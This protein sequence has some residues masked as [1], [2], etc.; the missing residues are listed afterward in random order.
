[1]ITGMKLLI[2]FLRTSFPH[3]PLI[4]AVLIMLATMSQSRRML[5]TGTVPT[6]VAGVVGGPLKMTVSWTLVND[7]SAIGYRV[8]RNEPPFSSAFVDVGVAVNNATFSNLQRGVTYF[9]VVQTKYDSTT[10]SSSSATVSIVVQGFSISG[11]VNFVRS[12]ADSSQSD[13]RSRRTELDSVVLDCS[14]CAWFNYFHRRYCL[15]V[16][17]AGRFYAGFQ[18]CE[19]EVRHRHGSLGHDHRHFLPHAGG[20]LLRSR[21]RCQ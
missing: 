13:N 3:N 16:R 14:A 6:N 11:F 18:L 8:T 20:A 21:A 1:M 4:L 12:P 2:V 19:S 10:F 9:A 7:T 5:Q 17:S 15:A